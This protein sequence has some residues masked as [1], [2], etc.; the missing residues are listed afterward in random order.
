MSN[1]FCPGART[2]CDVLQSV[3]KVAFQGRRSID[4]KHMPA[5]CSSFVGTLKFWRALF[6][7][8]ANN[9]NRGLSAY[10]EVKPVNTGTL[11]TFKKAFILQSPALAK[12][13]LEPGRLYNILA[14]ATV[15]LPLAGVLHLVGAS[16]RDHKD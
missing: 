16:L 14:F 2:R 5:R 9:S 10:R 1:D 6:Q 8:V 11:H 12:R 7:R 15:T 4:C 13:P 3:L